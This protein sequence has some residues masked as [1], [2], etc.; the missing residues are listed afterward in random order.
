MT[1]DGTEKALPKAEAVSDV[2]SEQAPP[3][4]IDWQKKATLVFLA[5]VGV[6]LL[7]TGATGSRMIKKPPTVTPSSAQSSPKASLRP[8]RVAATPHASTSSSGPLAFVKNIPGASGL[9]PRRTSSRLRALFQSTPTPATISSLDF[10]SNQHSALAKELPKPNILGGGLVDPEEA[11]IPEPAPEDKV[12][13]LLD[14]IKAFTLAT[15]IT[16]GTTGAG[17]YLLSRYLGANDIPTFMHELREQIMQP[18]A[19][20]VK[21]SDFL[22]ESWKLKEKPRTQESIRSEKEDEEELR[23]IFERGWRDLLKQTG[24]E[25]DSQSAQQSEVVVKS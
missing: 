12:N 6:T 18:F 14:A 17:I 8:A 5:S 19:N 15:T 13:A 7:L 22:P 9:P 11:N 24:L 4:K 21:N 23:Q 1:Q 10:M 20:S 3:Q 25:D 16:L 2:S